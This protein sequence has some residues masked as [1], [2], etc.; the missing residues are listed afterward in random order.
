[1]TTRHQQATVAEVG[2]IEIISIFP[3]CDIF[4]ATLNAR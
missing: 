1:M 3:T 2:K 4:Q